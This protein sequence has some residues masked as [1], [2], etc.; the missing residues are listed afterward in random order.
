MANKDEKEPTIS[1]DL[2]VTKYKMA[3]EMSNKTMKYLVGKCVEGASVLE[4]CQ[5]GDQFL[6]E[7]TSKV[8]KKEKEMKKGIAFPT[9]I[10]VNN[11]I[12][13]Y[14][15]L[16]SEPDYS[17]KD[18]DVVKID[19]GAHIDGFI[20]VLAH[21]VVVGASK[22]RKVTDRKADLIMAT[23]MASEAALRLVKPGNENNAVTDAVQKIAESYKCKPIEDLR[24]M[25]LLFYATKVNQYMKEHEKCEFEMHEVYAI[26]VLVST[27][28][29]KGKEMN[30]RTTI[31]KKTDDT[32]QLKM[33]ASRAFYSE[34]DKK[35]GNMPFTLR[36]LED[37]KKAK[38]GV[39]ECVNHKLI[40]PFT[41]LFEKESELV[42]QFKF[43]V[44]LMPSGSHKITDGPFD[45]DLYESEC[46]VDNEEL[47]NLLGS[48]V[49]RRQAKKKK[50]KAGKSVGG[51]QD[52]APA[53]D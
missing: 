31:Y 10:S 52:S 45:P 22:E 6:A 42:A 16:A 9:S 32:Y 38:M 2:V 15:P 44:L 47:K 13:H 8:F 1:E 29:G 3:G 41:V 39:V 19:L 36:A 17:L 46:S 48:S 49:N 40:E 51:E 53:E 26:D 33:K 23:R 27:G 4:L 20:A 30:T 34:V 50:K 37:E 12:C 24:R 43:T 21:T 14:S 7:E 25:H 18:N 28:D 11:C 35:F 5:A